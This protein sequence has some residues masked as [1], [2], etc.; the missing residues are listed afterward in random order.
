MAISGYKR[1]QNVSNSNT[2]NK[3][4]KELES[5][6]YYNCYPIIKYL[7]N[8]EI[9]QKLNI[10]SSILY[11]YVI[12]HILFDLSFDDIVELLNYLYNDVREKNSQETE[13]ILSQCKIVLDKYIMEKDGKKGILLIKNKI[14]QF[15]V[16]KKTE[17]ATDKNVMEQ[18]NDIG[19]A[20]VMYNN[21]KWDVTNKLSEYSMMKSKISAD[22]VTQKDLKNNKLNELI[23]F[24]MYFKGENFLVFK[25][26]RM[27]DKR[28]K[29]SRCDQKQV[30]ET[31]N[32]MFDTIFN[33]VDGLKTF[34]TERMEKDNNN[35]KDLFENKKSVCI[36]EEFI[37]YI[38]N[39]LKVN[40]KLWFFDPIKSTL[41]NIE[42]MEA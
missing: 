24:I 33:S 5:N 17:M 40:G 2:S 18:L 25:T 7:N 21:G 26:K 12:T 23:G 35:D 14:Q 9:L 8:P 4:N 20:L 36:I 34:F 27:T 19:I 15:K 10:D 32:I 37:L 28:S 3:K 13:A 31:K 6:W 16:N 1:K 39:E 38:F 42:N 30:D 41:S 29:G 11:N 22:I